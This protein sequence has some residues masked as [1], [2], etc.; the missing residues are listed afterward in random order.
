MGSTGR[1]ADD[2]KRLGL[3]ESALD[4]VLN[5][6][7]LGEG[8]GEGNVRDLTGAGGWWMTGSAMKCNEMEMD[9]VCALLLAEK[10]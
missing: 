8:F 1:L 10:V 9:V 5:K 6:G 7:Y 4:V 3:S 2:G